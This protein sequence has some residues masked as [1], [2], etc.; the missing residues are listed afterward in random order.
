MNSKL[1]TKSLILHPE[2]EA[3]VANIRGSRPESGDA[4]SLLSCAQVSEEI[5][6]GARRILETGETLEKV[7]DHQFVIKRADAAERL[8]FFVISGLANW[9]CFQ[10]RRELKDSLVCNE[11]PYGDRAIDRA[12][13]SLIVPPGDWNLLKDAVAEAKDCF[14]TN[15]NTAINPGK[16]TMRTASL[17]RPLWDSDV[18]KFGCHPAILKIVSDYLGMYPILLRINLLLSLNDRLQEKSSQFPH[19]DPEDFQQVKIFLYINDVDEDT[20]PFQVLRADASDRVQAKYDYRFGRLTDQQVF[21]VAG[22]DDLIMCLGPSGTSN[23][24]DTSRGFHFGSR[25]SSKQRKLVMYQ[26]VTPFAASWAISDRE[27]TAKYKEAAKQQE[28]QSGMPLSRRDAYLLA[29]NR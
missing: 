2:I 6:Q 20:G 23:F 27:I 29:V 12:Q 24:A 7:T 16:E 22:K 8:A 13:G 10:E 9:K 17:K 28:A 15:L 21:D 14:E 19:L 5:A 18:F 4:E 3:Y 1:E 26:Y 25:P 11:Q